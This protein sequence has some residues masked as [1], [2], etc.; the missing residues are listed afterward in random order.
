MRAPA[1]CGDSPLGIKGGMIGWKTVRHFDG[2]YFGV[3]IDG[4][5]WDKSLLK[6]DGTFALPIALLRQ[7]GT[8]EF[9]PVTTSGLPADDYSIWDP[10]GSTIVAKLK[11][12]ESD[13]ASGQVTVLPL[14]FW[15]FLRARHPASSKKLR[16]I[17][18]S[19]CAALLKA[20]HED[21][22]LEHAIPRGKTKET[23]SAPLES[24]LP[25]VK[26]LLPTAPERMARRG[27]VPGRTG[28]TS[29]RRARRAARPDTG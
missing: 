16:G 10:S 4:R 11:D 29:K 20:A 8:N 13:Y 21:R 22:E 5:R 26:K 19:D 3:G 6:D 23:A 9:L 25:A 28:R 12:F 1:G 2:S 18:E 24:L 14:S 27:R 7:V 17:S 15:H